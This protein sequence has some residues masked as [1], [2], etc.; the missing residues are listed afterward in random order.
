MYIT[1]SLASALIT[2]CYI[3]YISGVMKTHKEVHPNTTLLGT[4]IAGGALLLA[5]F[6]VLPGAHLT[7]PEGSDAYLYLLANAFLLMLS[8]QLYL[9]AYAHTDVANIT[10]FSPLTP[11]FAIATG[12]FMLGETLNSYELFGITLICSSIYIM[13]LHRRKGESL[14][15]ALMTP[16]RNIASSTPVLMGFLSTIPT[17]FAA[18]FQKKALQS[19]DPA[20]FT[21]VLMLTIG[22]MAFL[23]EAFIRRKPLAILRSK[24]QWWLISG[25][26][27]MLSQFIFCY[28]LIAAPASVALV[29]QRL[30]IVFQVILA[31]V[32]LHEKTDIRK[33]MACSAG[34]VAGFALLVLQQIMA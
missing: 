25:G 10:I 13:F 28:V 18:V 23:V 6:A 26:L 30:S 16:F 14:T 1:W 27:L 32:W 33:R 29:L 4:H 7:F 15:H 17:A 19:F 31:Y 8:R 11:M 20:T 2:A 12:H 21:I 24:P 22:F 34:A 9:Y 5:L 3:V